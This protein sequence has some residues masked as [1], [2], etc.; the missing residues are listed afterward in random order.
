MRL[1]NVH[2]FLKECFDID[3]QVFECCTP[4]VQFPYTYVEESQ[5]LY[6][7][8]ALVFC[9]IHLAHLS[10][11]GSKLVENNLCLLYILLS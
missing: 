10:H 7:N 4:Y 1:T 2:N 11:L 9:N 8:L 5:E 3:T 6:Q